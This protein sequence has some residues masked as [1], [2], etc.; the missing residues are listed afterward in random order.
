VRE[1][2]TFLFILPLAAALLLLVVKGRAREVVVITAGAAVAATVTVALARFGDQPPAFFGLWRD[3]DVGSIVFWSEMAIAMLIAVFAAH[4]RRPDALALAMVQAGLSAWMELTHRLPHLRSDRLFAVDRLSMV[5]FLVVGLLGPLIAIHALGYMR[6]YHRHLPLVRGRR[7]VFFFLV[8]AF[9]AAMFGLTSANELSL[10]HLF[11]ELTTL[12]SFLLIG[13]TQSKQTIGYAFNALSM[14]L[15]GGVGFTI[16]I[17][18]LAK[19]PTGLDMAALAAG[20]A[21]AQA[22]PAVALLA[23]AGLTK[24]AQM[25]FSSWLLGAM[26]A[27]TPTSALLHSSTMVK[28][29][30]FLLLRLSFAMAGSVVGT[31]VAV[32]GLATFALVSMVAITESNAKRVLAWS[33]IANLGLVAA[34]AGIASPATVWAGVMIIIFHAVAKSL[35]FLVVGTLENRLYTKDLERFDNL[36]WRSPRASLFALLGGS[37]MLIAPFGLTVAKWTAIRALI[38]LPGWQGPVFLVALAY[39]GAATIFYWSKLLG[40]LIAARRIDEKER[41]IESRVSAF[42][43]AAHAAHAAL[44]IALTLGLGVLSELLVA[45]LAFERFGAAPGTLLHVGPWVLG[46]LTLAV[47]ALPALAFFVHRRKRYELDRVYVCG[48]PADHAHLTQSARGR[49][50]PVSLR[51]YYLTGLID[52]PRLFRWGTALCAA[53][54]AVMILWPGA[55]P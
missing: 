11:W 45:P 24:S 46:P 1:I 51:N 22:L 39:G 17:A 29:G 31:A 40:K 23:L 18:L 5:M 25:P 55:R 42:E 28:A 20:P 38:E 3:F 7:S 48:R 54:V 21:S 33:T 9:L 32:I 15:L 27:P 6:D 2:L 41:A 49:A 52:G 50:A 43:W 26:Y 34:C 47:L 37:A 19:G 16:A 12:I 44:L 30:V 8:F 14:N 10:L 35:L 4:H 53:A 13:Y 36:L